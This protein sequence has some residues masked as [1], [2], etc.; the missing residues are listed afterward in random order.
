MAEQRAMYEVMGD[1]LS[2]LGYLAGRA[3]EAA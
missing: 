2:E 3:D 1:K